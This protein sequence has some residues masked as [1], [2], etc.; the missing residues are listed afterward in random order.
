[1]IQNAPEVILTIATATGVLSAS[2]VAI[3]HPGAEE[4]A[5]AVMWSTMPLVGALLASGI[6]FLLGSS[7]EPRKKVFGRALSALGCGVAGPRLLV[8][9]WPQLNE[10]LVDP[11]ILIAIGGICGLVGYAASVAVINWFMIRAP[12][13]AEDRLNLFYNK[14]RNTNETTSTD[15]NENKTDLHQ[16]LVHDTSHRL[17]GNERD[18]SVSGD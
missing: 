17:R 15:E 1:M 4:L 13:I 7:V 18:S 12:R 9:K 3:A 11:I 8:Y 10:F 16:P 6:S 2:A 5:A 14:H